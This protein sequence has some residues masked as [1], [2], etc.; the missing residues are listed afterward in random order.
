MAWFEIL[1]SYAIKLFMRLT[2]MQLAEV[3]CTSIGKGTSHRSSMNLQLTSSRIITLVNYSRQPACLVLL[4]PI[5]VDNE[6]VQLEDLM[7]IQMEHSH[8][9]GQYQ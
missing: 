7:D 6:L 5:L 3:V 2:G 9:P 4:G 8:D 1:E